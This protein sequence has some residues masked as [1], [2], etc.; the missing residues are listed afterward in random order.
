MNVNKRILSGIIT[1][2]DKKYVATLSGD[3]LLIN[4]KDFSTSFKNKVVG[5]VLKLDYDDNNFSCY[6]LYVK[7]FIIADSNTF[8]F[9]IQLMFNHFQNTE[10]K[11]FM[12]ESK[13]FINS[14][15]KKCSNDDDLFEFTKNKLEKKFYSCE[16]KI[17]DDLYE[18]Y[19]INIANKKK[20]NLCP[21]EFTSCMM[22]RPLDGIFYNKVHK[23]YN[24]VIKLLQFVTLNTYP[25]ID[26]FKIVNSH[27]GY[28]EVDFFD[29]NSVIDSNDKYL[30]VF[31][32]SS[33]IKKFL[34]C[35]FDIIYKQQDLY[36]F[37]N[38]LV[39]KIDI[40]RM[41]G[42]FEN[43]FKKYVEKSLE[44]KAELDCIKQEISFEE[45]KKLLD[46]FSDNHKLKN[47]MDFDACKKILYDYAGTLKHKLSFMLNDFC[48]TMDYVPI[49]THFLYSPKLFDERLKNARNAMCHGL[50]D[51]K[52][53]WRNA[54]NDTFLL[55]ELIYYIVLKYGMKLSIEHIKECI[56]L[57]FG[58]LNVNLSLY[59]KDDSRIGYLDKK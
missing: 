40:V 6:F 43:M 31:P 58:Y 59:K 13:G 53:D 47:N 36:H 12:I 26:Q 16:I 1:I 44:Y 34:E 24:Y 10:Y 8:L 39:Y 5:N 21:A 57:S 55:Q 30:S 11:Y 25:I 49:D 18:C 4:N 33:E 14:I 28:S 51:K 17:N 56:D 46:E 27:D 38:G 37:N 54:A 2:D 50:Y 3:E 42:L 52:I 19:F 48:E 7:N 45:L 35:F 20:N 29:D 9:K 23:V 32:F 41:S 22:L 15:N